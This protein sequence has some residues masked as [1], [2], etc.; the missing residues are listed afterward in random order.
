MFTFNSYLRNSARDFFLVVKTCRTYQTSGMN[1]NIPKVL[2]VI[3]VVNTVLA[4]TKLQNCERSLLKPLIVTE[5]KILGRGISQADVLP[6]GTVCLIRCSDKAWT[7]HGWR[8]C[9]NGNWEGSRI[10]CDGHISVRRQLSRRKREKQCRR[11]GWIKKCTDVDRNGH[12]EC[13]WRHWLYKCKAVYD[14]LKISCPPY[15]IVTA[16]KEQTSAYVTWS[17]P[18]TSGGKGWYSAVSQCG[19]PGKGMLQAGSYEIK[20]KVSD[21]RTWK[22]CSFRITVN[23]HKCDYPVRPSNGKVTCKTYNNDVLWGYGCKFTCNNGYILRGSSNVTCEENGGYN[24]DSPTCE[25]KPCGELKEMIQYGRYEC[26][27]SPHYGDTCKLICDKGFAHKGSGLPTCGADGKWIIHQLSCK[28]VEAPRFSKC[29]K[30]KIIIYADKNKKTA[31]LTWDELEA[32]DNS[33][34]VSIQQLSG[35]PKGTRVLSGTYSVSFTA[36]DA[37]GLERHCNFTIIVGVLHCLPPNLNDTLMTYRCKGHQ[38]GNKCDLSCK[39]DQPLVGDESITCDKHH[40]IKTKAFWNF[41]QRPYCKATSC[42]DFLPPL[43]GASACDKWL[44]GAICSILCNEKYDVPRGL[45]NTKNTYV[46]SYTTGKWKPSVVPDCTKKRHS[47]GI[48]LP[49]EVYLYYSGHC[50]D[51]KDVISQK[52]INKLK[53]MDSG[54]F[55]AFCDPYDECKAENVVVKC[56]KTK[57]KRSL[58]RRDTENQFFVTWDFT[59]NFTLINDTF[60]ASR[61]F[62]E[63][64]LNSMADV[65]KQKINQGEFDE[66]IPGLQTVNDSFN[67]GYVGFIC[68]EG[69]KPNYDTGTCRKYSFDLNVVLL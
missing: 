31:V 54:M 7:G 67:I 58:V 57:R 20:Y 4:Q 35:T 43:H 12:L 60:E 39:L 23:V 51:V 13:K 25:P 21:S 3:F 61:T 11:S 62:Y 33:G 53:Y 42:S 10:E 28:D 34:T 18:T 55:S 22:F 65:V 17:S 30:S 36:K 9:V 37:A 15:Q 1:N 47:S 5:C 6:N 27:I 66:L 48:K 68:G 32:T 46:C 49:G 24:Q 38:Y 45:S 69:L 40:S 50:G 19:G 16:G 2:L 26:P 59:S 56:G 29:P 64:K 14:E 52:F 8:K 41:N 44:G 63:S